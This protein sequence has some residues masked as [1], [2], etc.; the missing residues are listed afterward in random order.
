M[1]S[2][3]ADTL[4][5]LKCCQRTIDYNFFGKPS[6]AAMTGAEIVAVDNACTFARG[7]KVPK[8]AAAEDLAGDLRTMADLVEATVPENLALVEALTQAAVPLTGDL[9]FCCMRI[10]YAFFHTNAWKEAVAVEEPNAPFAGLMIALGFPRAAY[11]PAER[12][13]LCAA[14]GQFVAEV[15]AKDQEAVLW[16]K[17]TADALDAIDHAQVEAQVEAQAPRFKGVTAAHVAAGAA[18]LEDSKAAS[19]KAMAPYYAKMLPPAPR[20]PP[21]APPRNPPR[22]PPRN[23]PRAPP[24]ITGKESS[25]DKRRK[26]P[27]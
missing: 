5:H 27:Y 25:K 4:R 23:P 10:R 12:Q 13:A 24:R 14:L 2:P 9:S 18:A 7:M 22:A 11:P 26:I 17:T 21:R 15:V 19:R 20:N 3:T 8:E 1:A 16:L 6:S